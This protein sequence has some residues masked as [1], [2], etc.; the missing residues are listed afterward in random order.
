MTLCADQMPVVESYSLFVIVIY[1]P[2]YLTPGFTL[3]PL[4]QH[5]QD[6]PTAQMAPDIY[7]TASTWQQNTTTC[8]HLQYFKIMHTSVA[9]AY[10]WQKP[11][12]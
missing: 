6:Q 12:R 5:N 2:H 4:P 1:N 8:K 11:R 7:E 9:S 10:A 3:F